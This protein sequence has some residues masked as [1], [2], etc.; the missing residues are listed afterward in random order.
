MAAYIDI[1][2]PGQPQF[3]I[4]WHVGQPFKFNPYHIVSIDVDGDEQLCIPYP[5]R[6]QRLEGTEAMLYDLY[7][8]NTYKNCK[9][10]IV[11]EEGI[12]TMLKGNS[13]PKLN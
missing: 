2:E 6:I 5:E 7:I 11:T 3:S 9:E 12:N 8:R 1:K 10:P 4:T 13:S